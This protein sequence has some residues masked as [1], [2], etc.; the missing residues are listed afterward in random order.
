VRRGALPERPDADRNARPIE[1]RIGRVDQ[2]VLAKMVEHGPPVAGAEGV[3][4]DA[5]VPQ[6]Q[7]YRPVGG[8]MA[9]RRYIRPLATVI[10]VAAQGLNDGSQR[11][12][13]LPTSAR[14]MDRIISPPPSAHP[15]SDL[16]FRSN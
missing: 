1:R 7:G 3:D 15:V 2:L 8:A 12:G 5:V 9:R 14:G 6:Q 4:D 13:G 11:H 16:S 10:E